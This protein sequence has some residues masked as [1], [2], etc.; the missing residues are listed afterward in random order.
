MKKRLISLALIL[1]FLLAL[2]P[3]AYAADIGYDVTGGKIY[4][5]A[6]TGTITGCDNTVT[7]ADIPSEIM[8]VKV[9]AIGEM[10]FD[11][12]KSLERVTIPA[13]ITSIEQFTFRGCA[14]LI[15]V[16]LPQTLVSIGN[17][18]FLN[19]SS[20]T[21][22]T[23]PTGVQAIGNS[24]FE[25]CSSLRSLVI[26]DS[27]T[28]LGTGVCH[29]C[30][31]LETVVIGSGVPA[32]QNY[33]FT[34]CESLNSVTIGKNV[35]SIGSYAFSTCS[36]LQSI[37]IP[38]GVE[39]IGEGAF[40]KCINLKNVRIPDSV[41]S[42][43]NTAFFICSSL[44]EIT[45]PDGIT[46]IKHGTFMACPALKKIGIPASVTEIGYQ[47]FL[48]SDALSDIYFGGDLVQWSSIDV[49]DRN[50][51]LSAAN[52]HLNSKLIVS[53]WAK[54]EIEKAADM[55]LI[56]NVLQGTD[57]TKPISRSEF[58]AVAVKVYENLSGKTASPV[59]NNPF[60]DTAD[61]D[62]L[63]AYAIGA[64]NGTS[65]T[66]FTPNA[67]L[68]REQCATMLTRVYKAVTLKGWT[69]NTDGNFKLDYTMPAKFA[70][71]SEISGWARDS[72][73]FMAAN[74]IINGMGG[75]KFAPKN[76]TSA[77]EAVGYANATREQALAIAVRM[78][79]NL[80]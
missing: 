32:V 18:A 70:D 22:I 59:A 42:I 61:T 65:A 9:T 6:A 40:F 16:T 3:A 37:I 39:S 20:L 75:N 11:G 67:N 27:V 14:N 45:I 74:K 66:T 2:M 47:A 69:L 80:G 78:V 48:E 49:G 76:S 31:S 1:L 55:D 51:P 26:P 71:D 63:R 28:S 10:A 25:G 15:A 64:V 17:Y 68:N 79:E 7:A 12:C 46:E 44:A 38:D 57:L 50:A 41:T 5:N 77:Q 52:L 54:T 4:F 21:G 56:P 36:S 72:V 58:A 62:V 8:G 24:A 34:E 23:I 60:N 33:S 13:G 30:K 53:D 73:Y 29:F 43:G 35:Q 19:C